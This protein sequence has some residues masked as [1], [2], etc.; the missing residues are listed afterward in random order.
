MFLRRHG[1]IV[2]CT[3]TENIQTYN[4]AYTYIYIQLYTHARIHKHHLT[5][6]SHI[7]MH[8][9]IRTTPYSHTHTPWHTHANT[10]THRHFSY[11][12][13]AVSRCC[14]RRRD[15]TVPGSSIDTWLGLDLN[16]ESM[17]V[18]GT[19]CVVSCI[20][21]LT[22]SNGVLKHTPS[23][24]P[25]NIEQTNQTCVSCS[26]LEMRSFMR[27]TK[28]SYPNTHTRSSCSKTL[29][30]HL[31]RFR[32]LPTPT[33]PHTHPRH[34]LMHRKRN[35]WEVGGRSCCPRHAVLRTRDE[36]RRC[37]RSRRSRW[38][39][40]P[41]DGGGRWDKIKWFQRTHESSFDTINHALQIGLDVFHVSNRDS[42]WGQ[43]Q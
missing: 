20:L 33:P 17:E 6:L 23:A 7:H 10:R 43:T 2:R 34:W 22:T 18:W 40:E 41:S 32:I 25:C 26:R 16:E 36:S 31:F 3:E 24:P 11:H 38:C 21:L 39:C 9:H 28:F 13:L 37:R 29:V 5:S 8:T 14:S 19:F 30:P 35:W 42:I 4:Y 15:S 1:L 12:T 27:L